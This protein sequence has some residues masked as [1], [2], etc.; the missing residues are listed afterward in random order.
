MRARE[1]IASNERAASDA[2]RQL[3]TAEADFRLHDRDGNGI[4][5]FWVGDVSGLYTLAPPR[6]PAT[7]LRL[8]PMDLARADA[9]PLGTSLGSPVP[10]SGYL[11]IVLQFHQGDD[12]GMQAV[13]GQDTDGTG[14]K[15]RNPSAFG[16]CAYPVEYGVTGRRTFLVNEGNTILTFDMGGSPMIHWPLDESLQSYWEKLD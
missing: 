16:F 13:Y 12:P 11:F 5:D 7:P 2:L 15:V 4:N 9:R 6:S 14:R 10:L 1:R 3:V 8:I